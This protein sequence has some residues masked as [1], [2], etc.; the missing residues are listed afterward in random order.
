MTGTTTMGRVMRGVVAGLALPFS[1]AALAGDFDGSR[2]MICAT[3]E[4]LDCVSGEECEK[5]RP[6][7]IGAPTFLR[8]DISNKSVIGPKQASPIVFM[9]RTEDQLLLQGKERGFGWT[10]SLDQATG[11]LVT[12]L[13]NQHGA[14][15]LFGSCTPL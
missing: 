12:T 10:M 2:L 1:A 11:K 15:V 4:A 5:G 14:Y 3:V 7:D 13:V 9:E 8:I 6:E